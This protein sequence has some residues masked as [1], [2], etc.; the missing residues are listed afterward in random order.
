MKVRRFDPDDDLIIVKARVFG[1]H[2]SRRLTLALDTAAS[3]THVPP[4][5]VDEL[6]YGPA[7][8]EAITAVRSA[9][10]KE[11]GYTLRVQRFESLG[12]GFDDFLIHVHDLPT[13]FG[14]DG[15]LGLSFLKRFNYEIRSPEGRILI[16]RAAG[17]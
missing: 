3:H 13:G 17:G 14:I 6:G 12:F 10:G 5:I 2:G 9:I 11:P 4:D 1:R 8:G 7:E 16:E 15:L